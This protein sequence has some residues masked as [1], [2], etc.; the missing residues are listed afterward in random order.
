MTNRRNKKY[1][2][3]IIATRNKKKKE[4]ILRFLKGVKIKIWSLA[5]YP[6]IPKIEEDGATFDENAMKK[7]TTVAKATGK[8][9][10]GE[11]SG[12]EVDALDG[13]PGIY[14]ARFSG[15][16]ANDELNNAK[17]LKML[18]G[19]PLRKR[20]AQYR[21]SVAITQ[22]DGTTK[23]VRGHC[24]GYIGFERKGKTGF[25]YDPIFVMPRYSKTFA[26]LGPHIKDKMSHR[27]MAMKQ[28][29]RVVMRFI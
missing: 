21:C 3:L 13:R 26:E 28:A 20:T 8:L 7:S 23:V 15:E 12:L 6:N 2:E 9:T 10:L 16:D 5:D 19:L 27:A 1:K 22:P 14:S 29:R 11:D 25:G 18:K 17:L 4:E 24:R